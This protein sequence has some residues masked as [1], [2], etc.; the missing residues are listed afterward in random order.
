MLPSS[1]SNYRLKI[2]I[3]ER[4]PISEPMGFCKC[5]ERTNA[6]RALNFLYF[7][8]LKVIIESLEKLNF[9][10]VCC[11]CESGLKIELGK[12]LKKLKT[13]PL[14]TLLEIFVHFDLTPASEFG[15]TYVV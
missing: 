14:A 5:F 15:P 7:N 11:D 13:K 9:Y 2:L 1:C 10:F 3:S 4:A 8:S 12:I 6:V